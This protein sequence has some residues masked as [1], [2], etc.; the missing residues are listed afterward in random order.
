[1]KPNK[2]KSLFAGSLLMMG[3]MSNAYAELWN[4]DLSGTTIATLTV[5]GG[6][7]NYAF[8]FSFLSSATSL[9]NINNNTYI[10][11]LGV[12][13]VGGNNV[14]ANITGYTQTAGNSAAPSVDTTPDFIPTGYSFEYDFGTNN[15]NSQFRAGESATWNSLMTQSGG[16]DGFIIR[17]ATPGQGNNTTRFNAVGSLVTAVPEPETY[18]MFLAGLGLLGFAA[19]RN[20]LKI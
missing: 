17:L 3:M 7:S 5:T 1:M 9:S 12:D 2:L 15:N 18:A 14:G 19:R 10:Q 16:F 13:H 20:K 6:P 11:N 8:D 4:F